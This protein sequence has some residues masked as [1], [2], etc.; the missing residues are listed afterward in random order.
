VTHVKTYMAPWLLTCVW[1][2]LVESTNNRQKNQKRSKVNIFVF[3]ALSLQSCLWM[4]FPFL[5]FSF[6]LFFSSLFSFLSFSFSSLQYRRLNSGFVIAKQ[7]PYLPLEP[8][9]NP[10]VVYLFVR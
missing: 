10:C 6:P 3:Q 4:F 5:S 7:A 2:R 1:T 9:P 8:C